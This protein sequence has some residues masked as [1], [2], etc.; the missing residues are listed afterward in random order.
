[1][2]TPYDEMVD[3]DAEVGLPGFVQVEPNPECGICFPDG[4]P[5]PFCPVHGKW[6][7]KDA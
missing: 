5:T 3:Y 1:M 6:S 2:T 4:E 7:K